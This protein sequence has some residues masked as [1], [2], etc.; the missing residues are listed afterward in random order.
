MYVYTYL[1]NVIPS[2]E[3]S[4]QRARASCLLVQCACL[5]SGHDLAAPPAHFQWPHTYQSLLPRSHTQFR[6]IA[7][8]PGRPSSATADSAVLTD[9]QLPTFDGSQIALA[10]WL[11]ELHRYE[12]LLPSELAY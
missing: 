2:C 1:D 3:R 5:V 12:H 10:S 4:L 9:E 11:R 6:R 7:T 8:M